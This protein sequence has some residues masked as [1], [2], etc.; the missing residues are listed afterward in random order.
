MLP[1]PFMI[2]GIVEAIRLILIYSS[3]SPITSRVIL[4]VVLAIIDFLD[5]KPNES[6]LSLAGVLGNNPLILGLIIK[7]VLGVFSTNDQES[8]RSFRA[9]KNKFIEITS[10]T[11]EKVL[12]KTQD[13]LNDAAPIVQDR[14]KNAVAAS[15]SAI[16]SATSGI[17]TAA[18]NIPNKMTIPFSFTSQTP[19]I[20]SAPAQDIIK[21]T[22]VP[23]NPTGVPVNPTDDPVNPVSPT[24][25]EIDNN[26]RGPK[27][28]L[29]GSRSI[30]KLEVQDA[31]AADLYRLIHSNPS[32]ICSIA[33]Q[34][35]IEVLQGSPFL[36]VY[37]EMLGI[38]TNP[39][40][41]KKYCESLQTQKI[42]RKTRKRRN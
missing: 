2:R 32:I 36:C 30:N 27:P 33:F 22:G 26:P 18:S 34:K 7:V 28:M 40:R 21:P 15:G 8:S 23:V 14:F 29:G 9:F 5:G 3:S 37:L 20:P 16:S 6:L 31:L 4:S 19:P 11:A 39:D 17:T 35:S 12:A 42:S 1:I 10:P 25:S 41:L 38:P 24:I 13:F